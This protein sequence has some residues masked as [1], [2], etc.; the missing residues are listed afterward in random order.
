MAEES[1]VLTPLSNDPESLT[2]FAETIGIDP[3]SFS[4][5]EIF[6]YD[7][8]MLQMIPRPVHSIIFLFPIGTSDG[9]LENRHSDDPSVDEKPD[10]TLPFFTYQTV[11][12][13]CGTIAVIHSVMNNLNHVRIIPD[14]WMSTFI[15]KS[16]T[17]TAQERADYIESNDEI[18]EIHEDAAVEDTTPMLEE[19]EMNHFIAFVAHDGKLW[20]LDGRKPRPICHGPTTDVL[21]STV[22]VLTE[23]FFP[24]IED[25]MKTS[26]VAFCG[27]S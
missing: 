11:P 10:P 5:N 22:K 14:S 21:A 20:E 4:F 18:Q 8:D 25:I 19:D 2:E 24:H 1:G 17:M 6:S 13:A 12:N 27:S 3:Q 23:E 7:E 9:V 15:E 26:S 16:Q